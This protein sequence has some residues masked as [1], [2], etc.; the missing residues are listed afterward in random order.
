[1]TIISERSVEDVERIMRGIVGKMGAELLTIR[2]ERREP[3]GGKPINR[4]KVLAWL[5]QRTKVGSEVDFDRLAQGT[6]LPDPAIRKVLRGLVEDDVLSAQADSSGRVRYIF[7]GSP[8][9]DED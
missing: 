2:V 6:R 7:L 9:E 4:P 3:R 5:E 8:V 1:M